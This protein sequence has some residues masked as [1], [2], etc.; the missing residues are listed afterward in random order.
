MFNLFKKHKI[1]EPEIKIVEK[2]VKVEVPVEVRIPSRFTFAHD[3]NINVK[4]YYLKNDV[5]VKFADIKAEELFIC[6]DL[7]ESMVKNET[8]FVST[9]EMYF[10]FKMPAIL[11]TTKLI[12]PKKV[13]CVGHIVVD[14]TTM[15][16][17]SIHSEG[18]GLTL[19][20]FMADISEEAEFII[21]KRE[22]AISDEIIE[23][24]IDYVTFR[25]SMFVKHGLYFVTF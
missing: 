9:K 22:S 1:T 4:K 23:G 3:E 19:A 11:P 17:C 21:M 15:E 12:S 7:A 8:E 6:K 25:Q 13:I 2:E 5:S 20:D 10:V 24:N 18:V 14:K 16:L